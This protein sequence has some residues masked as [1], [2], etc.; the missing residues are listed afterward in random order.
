MSLFAQCPDKGFLWNR[1]VFL[2]D[3]SVSSFAEQLK[4]LMTYENIVKSCPYNIDSV[5]SFLL[6]RIGWA[7]FKQD[8]YLN[9]VKYYLQA[10]DL[11]STHK[12]KPSIN[13]SQNIPF[14]FVLAGIYEAS[15]KIKDEIKALDSCVSTS[16]RIQ[17]IDVYCL[18]ALY[19]KIEYLFGAGDYH[20]CI[21]YAKMCEMLANE[22]GRG[23]REKKEISTSYEFSSLSWRV[24]AL[25]ELKDYDAAE[26]ILVNKILEIRKG[27]DK[28]YLG[29]YLSELAKLQVHKE[30]YEKALLYY[31][32]ALAYEQ[33][34]GH[35]LACRSILNN[36][37]YFIYFDHL[38][39]YDKALVYYRRALYYGKG[40]K[41]QPTDAFESLN[42]LAN[43]AN[44][45][46]RRGQHD[47]A[48]YYFQLA[49]DQIRPG[50]NESALL[51]A[52]SDEFM[53][54]KKN[55]YL[56][57][58]LMDM[59][60]AYIH[61]YNDTKQKGAI[62][63]ALRIYK[64]S[65][66]VLDKIKTDMTDLNSKLFW[67]SY[68]RRLYE[69]AI[70]GSYL[71]KNAALAFYFF[72]KS[73]SV[74]LNDQLN[75][76]NKISGTDILKTA[77]IKKRIL[78]LQ[79]EIKRMDSSTTRLAELQ[80]E[81][82]T[83]NQELN[84]V[85]Q[86]IRQTNPLYYQSF[87]DTSFVSLQDVQT[88]I[89]K[90]H[91]IL[92]E[93][94]SGDSSVYS[95]QVTPN[96]VYFNKIAKAAYDSFA[97]T[98]ISYLSNSGLLNRQFG[99]FVKTA[100][101]LYK[102]IFQDN[103]L[104]DGRII[105]SPDGRIF[106][107]E[108]L[109]TKMDFNAPAYLLDDHAVSYTYSARFL[110][111]HFSTDTIRGPDKFLGVAPVHYSSNSSLAALTGSDVSLTQIGSYFNNTNN[112][113]EADATRTNFQKQFSNYKVI[114]L[115]THASDTSNRDEPVI[116]FADSALYLSDLIP[117]NKPQTRLIV[118]SA[119]ETGNGKFYQGEGVF[120]FNRGFASLGIPASIT[121]LWA[122]D[123]KSTYRIT[124]LFYKYLSSGIPIDIALQKAK[125][126]FIQHASKENKL[127]YYWAATI[128]AGKSDA[129]EY[130]K[131]FPWKDISIIIAVMGL[132]FFSWRVF[133]HHSG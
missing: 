130:D 38:H 12:G 93:L 33:Q 85:E 68:S 124:E 54:N 44:V 127:P 13:E 9:A 32:Q 4:E 28:N 8:D 19:K 51:D 62:A 66:Q 21:D 120:G 88:G 132:F 101:R 72:E 87:L 3:S 49:F 65:D 14:Y 15:N 67:R 117:D 114:Q 34:A 133:Y 113:V 41:G 17:K 52:G 75:Q 39:D 112:L 64:I 27:R 74:L 92:L 47:S 103:P 43:I 91:R 86:I 31:N 106:P 69:H 115:Y 118:L 81:L 60:D 71:E 26:E 76:L 105:I 129:I 99:D 58:M 1:L 36:I 104:P 109:I 125:L 7:Y 131:K 46:V 79:L 98:Y 94:F 78:Q 22:Y 111:T 53:R 6:Q 61:K 5:H 2:R 110:L 30:N 29:T 95:L 122:V 97:G 50:L 10:I 48:K 24:A 83:N 116:Y 82:F 96:Q 16:I 89:L 100:G 63:D 56:L 108:S 77:R 80:T 57:D 121:N 11:V 126:D 119:C 123:S 84:R 70:E 35:I 23:G 25:L 102:L 55:Y 20:N 59:G 128:L 18:A 40:A 90:D 107:F 42:E 73:R 37:G 45:Y